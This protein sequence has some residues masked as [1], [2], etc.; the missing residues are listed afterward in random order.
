SI[1]RRLPDDAW[2]LETD[3]P[4]QPGAGHQ[5]ERNEPAYL[6]EVADCVAALR[7]KTRND[8]VRQSRVNTLALFELPGM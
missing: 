5:G 3:A 1:V 7:D 8:I 6:V 4:D 2:V